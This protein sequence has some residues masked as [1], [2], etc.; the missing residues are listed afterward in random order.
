MARVKKEKMKWQV[1]NTAIPAAL[2]F[3]LASAWFFFRRKKYE[4][5]V[6]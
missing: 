5:K 6:N 3:I 2:V 4:G 1:I